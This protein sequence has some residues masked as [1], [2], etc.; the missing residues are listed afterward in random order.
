MPL[1]RYS[2]FL[3]KRLQALMT[4]VQCIFLLPWGGVHILSSP[5]PWLSFIPCVLVFS[6][7]TIVD[8]YAHSFANQ[9]MKSSRHAMLSSLVPFITALLMSALVT[10]F[11]PIEV[12]HGLSVGV[13]LAAVLLLLATVSLTSQDSRPSHGLLVGYSSAG[14]PLYSSQPSGVSTN[15]LRPLLEQIMERS[16]SR[17][18]FY[19]LLLNLASVF[20]ISTI[21]LTTPLST[22]RHS[23]V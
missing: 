12:H 13:V 14:L 9:H 19:F 11:T 3:G 23:Q 4:V 2:D 21:P 22:H 5:T 6:L 16:E 20:T 15:W 8:F 10:Y 7:L 17:R 1:V 18:I